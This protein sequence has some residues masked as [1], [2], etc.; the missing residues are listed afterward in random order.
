MRRLIVAL[1]LS[2]SLLTFGAAA[3][4]P[5][6]P[7]NTVAPPGDQ[8]DNGR[9]GAAPTGDL[10]DHAHVP[11]KTATGEPVF[12]APNSGS[13]VVISPD[14]AVRADGDQIICRE[15]A[16]IGSRMMSRLCLP[17]RRWQQMHSD[18]QQFMRD[19]YEL[20]SQG[21]VHPFGP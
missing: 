5:P 8:T 4:T 2:S 20:S 9:V 12:N 1:A 17:K 19:A 18:G 7:A 6:A 21:G 3:Q 14:V 10:A 13:Q 16:I 11:T 15:T